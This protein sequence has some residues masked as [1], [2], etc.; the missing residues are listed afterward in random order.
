MLCGQE[1]LKETTESQPRPLPGMGME[2]LW[3]WAESLS[4]GSSWCFGF[5]LS[6]QNRDAIPLAS[7]V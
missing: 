7:F 5:R 3:P 6:I 4:V 2:E 1:S